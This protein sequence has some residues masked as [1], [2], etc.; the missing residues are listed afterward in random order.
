MLI[1]WSESRGN[2]LEKAKGSVWLRKQEADVLL[3]QSYPS[4][5]VAICPKF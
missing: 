5:N 2:A 4:F 3:I 1:V